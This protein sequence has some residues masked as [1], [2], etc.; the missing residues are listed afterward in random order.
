VGLLLAVL[1]PLFVKIAADTHP[2][3]IH[4]LSARGHFASQPSWAQAGERTI[5][6]RSFLHKRLWSKTDDDRGI[7]FVFHKSYKGNL[8]ASTGICVWIENILFF[9]DY[10]SVKRYLR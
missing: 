7:A 2:S 8:P 5:A 10:P 9:Y 3:L 6:G 1:S 4:I